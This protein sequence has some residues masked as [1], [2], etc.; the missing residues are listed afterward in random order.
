[1][2]PGKAKIANPQIK[3]LDIDISVST[4]FRHQS[5]QQI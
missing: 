5:N 2:I 1:M 4:L 3:I